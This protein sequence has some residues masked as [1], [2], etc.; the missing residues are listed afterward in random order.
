MND[1]VTRAEHDEL[2][3]LVRE[4]IGTLAA[5]SV[6]F[7]DALEDMSDPQGTN[8]RPRGTVSAAVAVLLAQRPDMSVDELVEATG[9]S[10]RHVRRVVKTLRPDPP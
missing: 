3:A 5:M 9:G 7:R 1:Y 2:R 8:I 10:V 4:V 6:G